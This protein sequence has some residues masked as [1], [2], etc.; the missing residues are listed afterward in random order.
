MSN[1][2]EYKKII[3]NKLHEKIFQTDNKLRDSNIYV[4]RDFSGT[5]QQLFIVGNWDVLNKYI[6]SDELWAI[7][8]LYEY[9]PAK[10]VFDGVSGNLIADT[11]SQE[12]YKK[13]YYNSLWLY[14][15]NKN[16]EQDKNFDI[17]KFFNVYSYLVFIFLLI[18]LYFV[19]DFFDK[20]QRKPNNLLKLLQISTEAQQYGR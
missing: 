7:L 12:L 9:R 8:K 14:D 4:N 6:S 15:E 18:V 2:Y 1:L 19:V 11:S 10:L 13:Y 17:R 20:R 5:I 16:K 3:D